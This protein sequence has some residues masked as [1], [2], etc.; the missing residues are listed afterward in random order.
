[1]NNMNSMD[2]MQEKGKTAAP[3]GLVDSTAKLILMNDERMNAEVDT[4]LLQKD[5]GKHTGQGH[6]HVNT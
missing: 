1:M 3:K 5:N 4:N 2:K 6:G